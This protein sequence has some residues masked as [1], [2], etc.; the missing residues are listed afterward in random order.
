MELYF[1][2]AGPAAG[3]PLFFLHGLFGNANNWAGA[4]AV[5]AKRGFHCISLDQRN[6]GRS[7]HADKMDYPSMARDLIDLA[8]RQGFERFSVVGHSMGGK[9]AMEAALADP[10]RI[11]AL[12]VVDIAPVRYE[13]LYMDFLQRPSKRSTC[14]RLR[15][16]PTR[17]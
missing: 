9:T 3:R 6:H 14:E 10:G 4:A 17:R 16:S 2:E 7:P 12:V 5:M 8:D 13:P 11:E 15:R 1:A